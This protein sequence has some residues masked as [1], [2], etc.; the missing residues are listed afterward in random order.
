M[1]F[2]QTINRGWVWAGTIMAA[3]LVAGC[4]GTL[5]PYGSG[6]KPGTSG[7]PPNVLQIGDL[8][9]V[10]FA[11]GP[12]PILPHEEHIK[13]DGKVSL[14]LIGKIQAAGKTPG[15]L[16]RDIQDAYV[17]RFYKHLTV[18][19][20][21][22]DR[23]YFVGGEVKQPSRQLYLGPVTVMGAIKSAGDFTDFANRRKIQITRADGTLHFVDGN[24][25]QR[26]PEHDLPVYPGDNIHVDRRWF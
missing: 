14:P 2:F 25:A 22:T 11:G 5:A 12:T 10:E 1:N 6:A 18:T 19:V 17:P 16:Q 21:P 8:V 20:R 26:D 24:R 7:P 9:K 3:L 15:S 23:F 4:G 13:D